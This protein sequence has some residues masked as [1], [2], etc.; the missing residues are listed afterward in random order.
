MESVNQ[1]Q[2]GAFLKKERERQGK[3]LEDISKTLKITTTNIHHLETG[4]L[5]AIHLSEIFIKSYLKSYI[6]ELGYDS[7]ELFK[8]FGVFESYIPP[9]KKI[10]AM[11]RSSTMFFNPF[12]TI[13]GVIA[14]AFGSF[15]YVKYMGHNTPMIKKEFAP[16]GA[17]VKQIDSVEDYQGAQ[18]QE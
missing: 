11:G 6:G 7:I 16:K 1:K 15:Y 9:Q 3:T 13:L 10:R 14:F 18:F 5:E 2:L 17:I 12:I 4:T 8:R